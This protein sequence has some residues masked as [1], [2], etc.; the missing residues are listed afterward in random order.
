MS[1]QN[2]SRPTQSKAVK[3]HHDHTPYTDFLLAYSIVR[4]WVTA[5]WLTFSALVVFALWFPIARDNM[6]RLNQICQTSVQPWLIKDY[7]CADPTKCTVDHAL[8]TNSSENNMITWYGICDGRARHYHDRVARWYRN[9]F[10]SLE[11]PEINDVD[12][13][14]AKCE[15]ELQTDANGELTEEMLSRITYECQTRHVETTPES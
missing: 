4:R 9:K 2:R 6:N 3:E 12:A 5:R 1:R 7:G 15:A 10:S 8:L 13:A 14:I 11:K